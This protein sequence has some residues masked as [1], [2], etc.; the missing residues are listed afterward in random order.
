MNGSL[1]TDGFGQQGTDALGSPRHQAPT[2]TCADAQAL[3]AAACMEAESLASR[4][5]ETFLR[6]YGSSTG[7]R[8]SPRSVKAIKDSSTS[9][10]SANAS[11]S[12]QATAQ[13]S[14]IVLNGG[15]SN[16]SAAE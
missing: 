10:L 2:L 13:S 3:A 16:P 1:I 12:E 5:N 4:Q 11:M 6:G 15:A 8:S 14:A 7:S 9:P